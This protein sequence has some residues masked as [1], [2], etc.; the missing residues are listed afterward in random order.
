MNLLLENIPRKEGPKGEGEDTGETEDPDL[1]IITSNDIQ[2]FEP[3]SEKKTELSAA[4]KLFLVMVGFL[5]CWLPYFLWLP[6]STLL[7]NILGISLSL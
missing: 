3:L 1:I 2:P 5:I 7:V 6:F 4:N